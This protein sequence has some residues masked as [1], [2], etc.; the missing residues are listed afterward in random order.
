MKKI[1]ILMCF[2][3]A[4]F[5]CSENKE[6]T[7]VDNEV[8][9]TSLATKLYHG[10]TILT[11]AGDQPNYAEAVLIEGE[12]IA[13][14]GTKQDALKKASDNTEIVD[15][16]GKTMLP[17]FVDGHAHFSN[18]ASQAIYAL[19]LP[20]PDAEVNSVDAAITTLQEWNTAENRAFTGWIVGTGFDDSVIEE[21]RFLTKHDLDKVSTEHPVMV[22]HISGHFAMVNSV[23][24]DKLNITADTPDPEGGLIRREVGSNEPNGVLEELAAIPHM[25]VALS[26]TT[27]EAIAKFFAAGQEMALSYGYTTAQEGRAMENHE[28]LASLA[29]QELLKIDVVSYVDYL[30]VDKYMQTKWKS[31]QYHKH[32]RIGGMK[33][34]LDGSPQGRTAWRT[35]PY[36]IP[37]D[38]AAKE[39]SGYP[40]F[41]NDDDLIAIYRKGFENN[42]QT[43]THANGDAAMDQMIRA[44][45]PLVDELGVGDRRNVLIHGQYVRDDQLDEFKKLDVIASLFPLHTYYWGDW[46]SQIIG[47]ELGKRISPTRTALNK[48]LKISI[49]TDA[50]VALPNLMR[51]VWTAVNRTSRSGKIV[52]E[53][54]RL[55]P[56]E[57]L[58][59]ITIWGAYQH[60]EESKKGTIEVGKLA[61]L[62]VL[63]ANPIEVEPDAIQDILVFQTIKNGDLIYTRQSEL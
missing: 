62:V 48:G 7:A 24:L 61:D 17:G 3:S 38:G 49:H 45:K 63:D 11:M 8:D 22:M 39:Y 4:L 33:V 59:A 52:G 15:L 46:H 5:A 27:P 44:M 13:F 30:F 53:G 20:S 51:V 21:K 28:L 9:A 14:V 10:G 58:Q 37:P 57:A 47:K 1:A 50:P 2:F 6:V 16:Q 55:T 18:F 29:E 32:Y 41:P 31:E 60:F 35:T 25:M 34:T 19:L 56:F 42:W 26:P 36:L 54:E 43:L 40:A 23:A 12:K